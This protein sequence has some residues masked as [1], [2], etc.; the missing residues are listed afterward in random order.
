MDDLGNELQRFF[1]SNPYQVSNETLHQITS[2]LSSQRRIA[3]VTYQSLIEQE[4]YGWINP[5]VFSRGAGKLKNVF[6]T[7]GE[8]KTIGLIMDQEEFFSSPYLKEISRIIKDDEISLAKVKVGFVFSGYH[9]QFPWLGRGF[10]S[11]LMFLNALWG[12]FLIWFLQKS[13][14]LLERGK[15]LLDVEGTVDPEIEVKVS[16]DLA[17]LSHATR[18]DEEDNEDTKV[19]QA[20]R[21]KWAELLHSRDLEN[22]NQT[23]QWY[24]TH[25]HVIGF[26]WGSSLTTKE[27]LK[28]QCYDFEVETKKISGLEGFIVLFT[29][30]G[31]QLFWV[32]GGWKNKRS[33]V[34]G[35]P[36]TVSKEK[37]QAG[38][39]YYCK[40]EI[41]RELARGF[42]DGKQI[43]SLRREEIDRPSPHVGLSKGIG[44]AVWNSMTRFERIRLVENL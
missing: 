38:K 14:P 13:R 30:N 10:V 41:T 15:S 36:Q 31:H 35:F 26:P 9:A 8:S 18:I 1:T 12:I 28:S 24:M 4:R 5:R 40:I 20:V 23:G 37:I 44:V 39:R 19:N 22:W 42:L 3:Y 33:E 2:K 25:G 11:I 21:G 43:W 29:C 34:A 27:I 6:E 32:L 7:Q 16:K 17:W